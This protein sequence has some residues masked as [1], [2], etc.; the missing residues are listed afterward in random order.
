MRSM[1]LTRL[2]LLALSWAGPTSAQTAP[3]PFGE[4]PA[5]PSYVAQSLRWEVLR[6][7]NILMCR[8]MRT[9][10]GAEAFALT[11]SSES[12]LRPRDR[13]RAERGMLDG[14][15][16]QW[17]RSEIA[18]DPTLLIREALIQLGEQRVVH[19]MVRTSDAETLAKYQQL[20]LSLTFSANQDQ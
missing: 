14:K 6:L 15:E 1:A 4:C 13:D 17:Y 7:P 10:D 19:I 12:P 18:N 20:V 11:F 3:H 16:V 2:L 8:A 5:L 9:E